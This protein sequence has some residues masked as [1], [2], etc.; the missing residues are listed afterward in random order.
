MALP[1]VTVLSLGGTISSTD[2]GSG[3]VAPSLSGNDLVEDV[4]EIAEVA[5]VAATSLRQVPDSEQNLEDLIE[6]AGEIQAY[7]EVGTRGVVVTQGTDT[8][9]GTSFVL[10][11]LVD[12]K[13]PVVVTSAMRHPSLPGAE[14]PA[15]LLASVQVAVSEAARGVGTVVVLNDEIHA[16]RFVQKT[17]TSNP[18]TFRSPLTGPIGWVSEGTPRIATRPAGRYHVPLPEETQYRPVALYAVSLGDDGRL[19]QAVGQLGYKGL[20]IEALGGG[21]VLSYMADRSFRDAGRGYT[22]RPGVAH[23]HRRG[24]EGHLRLHRLRDGSALAWPHQRGNAR[25]PEGAPLALP[26]APV[27]SVERRHY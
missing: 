2:T 9:E 27:G 18:A 16:A 7:I 25:R 15:N 20:V 23:R 12:A 8:I 22:G 10:D 21:H 6:L 26:A 11:L 17:H 4:P 24:P 13:A 5:E 1:T 14:G 19:L 3:G